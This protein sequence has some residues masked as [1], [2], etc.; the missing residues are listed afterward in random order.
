MS[1]PV[2]F[3]EM[4]SKGVKESEEEETEIRLEKRMSKAEGGRFWHQ[5]KG[6]NLN[7]VRLPT[8]ST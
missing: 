8:K 3:G 1:S 2:G 5:P 7:P 4:Q 6:Y